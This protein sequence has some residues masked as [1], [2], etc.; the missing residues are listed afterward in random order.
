MS[1]QSA[2]CIFSMPLDFPS[3]PW[4]DKA[5]SDLRHKP[6]HQHVV[7]Q[8]SAHD[9]QVEDLVGAEILMLGVEERQL[10]G[11]DDSAHGV[12]DAARQKPGEAGRRQGAD[13]LGERQDAHPAH[14]DVNQG[15]EPLGAGN[16]AGVDDDAHN[17]NA[18]DQTQQDPAGLVAQ[19]DH[20]YRSVGAGDEDE[21]H[22][23]VQFA[24]KLV[25]FG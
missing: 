8:A 1:P 6:V 9:E 15:R 5:C 7:A 18:P 21:D 10:Q 16:P 4:Y 3:R 19:H 14:S 17:G 22:H 20:A 25:D 11:I 12:D 2:I 13:D 23:V 24:Q